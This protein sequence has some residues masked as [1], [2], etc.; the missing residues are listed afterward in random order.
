MAFTKRSPEEIGAMCD[1]LEPV[2]GYVVPGS[3]GQGAERQ[4]ACSNHGTVSW[5]VWLKQ[6]SDWSGGV[7]ARAQEVTFWGVDNVRAYIDSGD[8][9]AGNFYVF[10]ENQAQL[11]NAVGKVLGIT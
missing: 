10:V 9:G 1:L 4:M 3:A 7:G 8:W 5:R 11:V 2:V 6:T